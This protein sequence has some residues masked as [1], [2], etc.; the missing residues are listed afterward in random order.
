MKFKLTPAAGRVLVIEDGFK[1]EGKIVI[2]DAV[3][4]RPS[5]GVIET[6]GDGVESFKQGDRVVYGMYSG[7]VVNIRHS[8]KTYRVLGVDEV[9]C[10]LTGEAELEGVG[11]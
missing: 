10:T 4:R 3:K 2:P 6:V 8:D 11:T 9:L 5:M 7:T 1:Y